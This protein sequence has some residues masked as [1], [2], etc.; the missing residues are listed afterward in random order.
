MSTGPRTTEGKRKSSLNGFI[1]KKKRS[2]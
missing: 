1:A 2:S